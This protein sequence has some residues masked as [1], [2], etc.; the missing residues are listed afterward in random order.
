MTNGEK[1]DELAK[2]HERMEFMLRWQFDE[3]RTTGY[4]K[5]EGDAFCRCDWCKTYRDCRYEYADALAAYR[6]GVLGQDD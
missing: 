3:H 5:V 2:Q 6:E 1:A 4:G